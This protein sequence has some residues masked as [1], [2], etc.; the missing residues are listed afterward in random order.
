M[1]IHET[2]AFACPRIWRFYQGLDFEAPQAEA[3]FR[4][5]FWDSHQLSRFGLCATYLL[6]ICIRLLPLIIVQALTG[7]FECSNTEIV[8]EALS[9]TGALLLGILSLVQAKGCVQDKLWVM[10]VTVA[11][12]FNALRTLELT[13]NRAREA[14]QLEAATS[15]IVLQLGTFVI[16]A[17]SSL[18]IATHV[19]F[20]AAIAILCATAGQPWHLFLPT[21][22]AVTASGVMLAYGARQYERLARH[23]MIQEHVTLARM[24]EAKEVSHTRSKSP[25]SPRGAEAEDLSILPGQ[26]QSLQPEASP[27]ESGG[28]AA[29]PSSSISAAAE[30]HRSEVIARLEQ[31]VRRSGQRGKP[32]VPR[33]GRSKLGEGAVVARSATVDVACL[34]KGQYNIEVKHTRLAHRAT[35][36]GPASSR[37]SAPLSGFLS[38][39]GSLNYS[40]SNRSQPPELVETGVNTDT[41]WLNGGWKCQRC[42][43][44][45]LAPGTPKRGQGMT[46]AEAARLAPLAR[47]EKR[48]RSCSQLDTIG[49]YDGVWVLRAEE[50]KGAQ[51]WLHRIVICGEMVLD[52]EG[53]TRTLKKD[54]ERHLLVGG[55]LFLE[56][57]KLRRVGR[58]GEVYHFEKGQLVIAESASTV[59]HTKSG[60]LLGTLSMGCLEQIG[61][62][63]ASPRSA[64]SD[65]SRYS[66]RA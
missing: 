28:L 54:G 5:S 39:S 20:V 59:S 64:H 32:P 34:T 18:T 40:D 38:S 62:E 65:A 35:P 25:K 11:I 15:V 66:P 41:Q 49:L 48:S 26:P 17:R 6:L 24:E 22:L 21:V 44:P 23:E 55:R 14:T 46:A 33:A 56:D 13:A 53:T 7:N 2:D 43:K 42:A 37:S 51:P 9:G 16:G 63:S 31:Y 27:A 58:S 19:A 52:S 57:G 1:P 4:R 47:K 45:P 29:L 8:L 10:A 36:Q 50:R 3:A 61:S 60:G 12:L 30:E